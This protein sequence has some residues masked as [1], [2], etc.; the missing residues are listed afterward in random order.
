MSK[1]RAQKHRAVSSDTVTNTQSPEQSGGCF[2]TLVRWQGLKMTIGTG[3]FFAALLL[4]SVYFYQITQD[5]WNW[6]KIGKWTLKIGSGLIVLGVLLTGGTFVYFQIQNI[7][8]KQTEYAGLN[9]GMSMTEVKYVKGVPNDMTNKKQGLFDDLIPKGIAQK[10]RATY[11]V[12]SPDGIEYEVT[13]PEGANEQEILDYAQQY[14]KGTQDDEAYPSVRKRIAEKEMTSDAQFTPEQRSRLAEIEANAL[15]RRAEAETMTPEQQ[16]ALANARRRRAEAETNKF[17]DNNYG[18]PSGF[19]LD[20]AYLVY[21]GLHAIF[22]KTDN[23]LRM[24]GCIGNG[25]GQCPR[26]FNLR[27]GSSEAEVIKTLGK[28]SDVEIDQNLIKRIEYNNLN[29]W[30]LLKQQHVYML[31]IKDFSYHKIVRQDQQ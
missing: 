14:H 1:A 6:L 29:A 24:I 26:L 16:Q 17:N 2:F 3:I 20:A 5:R 30:F 28:P 13:A 18:L 27:D 11:I 15:A 25:R 12:T 22:S 4:S 23:T 10:H 31:G 9:L 21:G 19:N 8:H 7:P